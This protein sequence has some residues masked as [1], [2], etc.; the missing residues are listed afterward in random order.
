MQPKYFVLSESFGKEI[1]VLASHLWNSDKVQS[2][3]CSL[4]KSLRPLDAV[5]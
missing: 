5:F 1:S 2:S 3:E 4:S